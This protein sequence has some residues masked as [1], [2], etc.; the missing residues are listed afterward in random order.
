MV[1]DFK[2]YSNTNLKFEMSCSLNT[3]WLDN[4]QKPHGDPYLKINIPE[5]TNLFYTEFCEYV[6]CRLYSDKATDW[7]VQGSD[8]HVGRH[9]L[10]YY[11]PMPL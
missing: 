11:L 7:M 4:S 6:Q 1:A 5:F 2:Q 10:I 9:E 8:L 3:M